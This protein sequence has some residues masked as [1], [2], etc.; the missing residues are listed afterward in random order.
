MK[1]FFLNKKSIVGIVILI[2][3]IIIIMIALFGNRAQPTNIFML[4]DYKP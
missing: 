1:I 2:I 4:R 3:A